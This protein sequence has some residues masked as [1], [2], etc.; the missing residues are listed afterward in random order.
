MDIVKLVPAVPLNP[1]AVRFAGGLESANEIIDW[2]F[3]K[4]GGATYRCV[5]TKYI[6]PDTNTSKFS[7]EETLSV[8]GIDQ[9]YDVVPGSWV[10]Y[11]KGSGFMGATEEE[12]QTDFKVADK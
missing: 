7:T 10:L 9:I 8:K 6:D 5:S 11:V 1:E 2:I 3:D 4:D 12:V